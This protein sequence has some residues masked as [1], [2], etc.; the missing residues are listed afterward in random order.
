MYN[1][2]TNTIQPHRRWRWRRSLVR[3]VYNPPGDDLAA[4]RVELRN[5][6]ADAA[7]L[8]GW[9]LHDAAATPN[10]YT[11]PAFSLASGAP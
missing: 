10:T 5:G 2:L 7:T 1:T 3:I 4:E 9:T 11:F 6:G 8:T